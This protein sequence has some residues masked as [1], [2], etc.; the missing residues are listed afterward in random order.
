MNNELKELGKQI[1]EILDKYPDRKLEILEYILGEDTLR[2]IIG[3]PTYEELQQKVNQLETNR[4]EVIEL[5]KS[6]NNDKCI[7]NGKE[8]NAYTF[9]LDFDKAREFIWEVEEILERGKE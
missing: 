4:D 6:K 2:E 1:I 9:V 5:L 8:K 3:K 7:I